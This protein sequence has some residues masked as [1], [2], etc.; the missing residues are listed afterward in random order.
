MTKPSAVDGLRRAV[1]ET[2]PDLPAENFRAETLED[3]SFPDASFDAALCIA[4]LH[5][6]ANPD[7]FDAMLRGVWRALKPGGILFCRLCS[8]IGV[9]SHVAPTANGRYRLGD[10]SERYLVD[11][12]M[13]LEYGETLGGALVEP[14]KSVNVEN[15]RCM[16]TWILNKI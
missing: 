11:L 12:S 2:R 1:G 5:F 15:Q 6:A 14:I 7:A 16:T 3:H 9:E 4:V 8:S 13:L 10:G